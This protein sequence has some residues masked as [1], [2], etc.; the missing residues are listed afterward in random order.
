MSAIKI[1][2][3][4]MECGKFKVPEDKLHM[5]HF[6]KRNQI[7]RC[8]MVKLPGPT[9]RDEVEE[10]QEYQAVEPEL[11]PLQEI[12]EPIAE[13]RPKRKRLTRREAIVNASKEGT[14]VVANR[15]F[16]A[17]VMAFFGLPGWH[18]FYMGN[19][20][21]ASLRTALLFLVVPA[22][23]VLA[24]LSGFTASSN[25]SEGT[26]AAAFAFAFAGLAFSTTLGLWVW[27]LIDFINLISMDERE[28]TFKHGLVLDEK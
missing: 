12:E 27:L 26:V 2:E 20:Q 8:H 15:F 22:L 11:E 21:Q 19:K 5:V 7:C 25:G 6:G 4:C 28:W 3:K 24:V 9:V 1:K 18:M 16:A 23:Y 17:A 10:I 13:V 14:L